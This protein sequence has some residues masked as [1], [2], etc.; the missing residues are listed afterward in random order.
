MLC[1]R[2]WEKEETK[3]KAS[4]GRDIIGK[5]EKT[6]KL[7]K[8]YERRHHNRNR[9]H[10]KRLPWTNL[11]QP[12]GQPIRNGKFLTTYKLSRLNQKEKVWIDPLLGKNV[13]ITPWVK[14]RTRCIT[15]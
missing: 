7:T 14:V 15:W 8:P 9:K 11:S 2:E 6:Q 10:E 5:Q 1:L 3:P 13:K 4:R 12:T